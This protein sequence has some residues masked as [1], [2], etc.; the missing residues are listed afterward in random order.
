MADHEKICSD[1]VVVEKIMLASAKR[2][3]EAVEAQDE[4][5]LAPVT[6]DLDDWDR[7]RAT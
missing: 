2:Q 1:R 6:E 4:R 7:V 3:H 5:K